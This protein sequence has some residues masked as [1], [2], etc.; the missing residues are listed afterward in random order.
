[1]KTKIFFFLILIYSSNIF[2]QSTYENRI[3]VKFKEF[4][5][6]I[7]SVSI[8]NEDKKL[9]QF[10]KDTAFVFLDIGETI[11]GFT[12]KIKKNKEVNIKVYQRFENSIT[13]MNEGPHCDLIDWK[14][15]DSN[16]REL[17]IE[18]E[19]FIL[20]GYTILDSEKFLNI[21]MNEIRK[22]V[23]IHC[24]KEWEEHIK[25]VKSPNEYPCGISTSRIFLKI[26]IMNPVDKSI[27]EKIISFE[28]PMG[29]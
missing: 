6:E 24:G 5:I 11:E 27:K 16:W 3:L 29:C 14:H 10:Q 26:K 15:Y 18:N 21:S 22:A 17:K 1:M 2:G 25:N 7:D 4:Q 20:D 12:A 23:N 13:I 19:E 8:W 9:N 28:I